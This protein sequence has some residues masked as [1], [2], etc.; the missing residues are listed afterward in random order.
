MEF[1]AAGFSSLIS[2][3]VLALF[4]AG[5]MKLFQ[6]HTVLTEIKDGLRTAPPA[7][8]SAAPAF[9]APAFTPPTAP[10]TPVALHSMSSG[11]DMLRALDA[12][13]KWDETANRSE[14]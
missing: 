4:A 9:A 12:Q 2:V 14:R 7:V 10:A 3:F 1:L 13:M 5:V 8:R 11:D 6:I